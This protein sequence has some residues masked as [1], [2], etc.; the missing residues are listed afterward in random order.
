MVNVA[1]KQADNPIQQLAEKAQVPVM[2]DAA[3][4][5]QLPIK[6]LFPTIQVNGVQH[7]HMLGCDS[8]FSSSFVPAV[9]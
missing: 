1:T 3:A 7:F 5:L 4:H 9:S 2:R 6:L 8:S